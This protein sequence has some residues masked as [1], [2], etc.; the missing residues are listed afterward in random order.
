MAREQQSIDD[1]IDSIETNIK[2]K[3]ISWTNNASGIVNAA[4]L[5]QYVLSIAHST[6]IYLCRILDVRDCIYY[7]NFDSH[8]VDV[9]PIYFAL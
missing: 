5:L 4:M 8:R 9:V 2:M 3:L 1:N 7:I 6:G